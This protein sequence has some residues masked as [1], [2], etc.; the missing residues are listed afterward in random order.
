MTDKRVVRVALT[1]AAGQIGY[2]ILFRIAS[3]EMFGPDVPVALH[4]LELEA[5]LPALEGVVMELEDGAF[6]LLHDIRYTADL[7]V[8]MRDVNWALLVGAAPRKAGMQRS[9]LLRINGG[10]FAGQGAAI[11]RFA[12]SDVRTLVV[13]NPC[14]TNALIAMHH[15]PDVPRDRFYAMTLLDENRAR[16]QLAIKAGVPVSEVKRMAIWGNHSLTQYPDV[17][18]ARIGRK[19]V[20]EVIQDQT[21]LQ[22]TFIE[23]VQRRGAAIIEARGASSAA[24]AANAAIGTVRRLLFE[25]PAD[26]CYSVGLCS[27]GQYD[28]PSGL[29]YSFPCRTQAGQL[30]VIE[31]LEHDTF[32]RD[33]LTVTL[34]ELQKERASVQTMGLLEQT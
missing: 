12:A 19:P 28:V 7:K 32:A 1:G 16:S 8:A 14:N 34:E 24:S 10:I 21:W 25:T 29:I 22:T 5:A 20:V 23:R 11:N 17:Y 3:G 6:P 4:L 30:S 18:H 27:T 26:E 13:G 31:G 33:R 2:A 15:A 9:D